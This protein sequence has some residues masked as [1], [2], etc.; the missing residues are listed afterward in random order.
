METSDVDQSNDKFKQSDSLKQGLLFAE[1]LPHNMADDSDYMQ[2]CIIVKNIM[3]E[4]PYNKQ[5]PSPCKLSSC[6]FQKL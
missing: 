2:A 6:T 3:G 1:D 4:A 5:T